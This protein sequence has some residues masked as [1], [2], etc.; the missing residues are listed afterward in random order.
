VETARTRARIVK[1][2]A[3]VIKRRGM[4]ESA[5]AGLMTEAGL[6]HGAFYRH[7]ASKDDLLIEALKE[8]LS[9]IAGQL[10]AALSADTTAG[11]APA[12]ELYLSLWHRDHAEQGCPIAAL[13]SELARRT[14]RERA[15][16]TS[17]IVHIIELL[18]AASPGKNRRHARQAAMAAFSTLVGAITLARIVSDDRLS[19]EILSAAKTAVAPKPLS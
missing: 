14:P 18:A 4:S 16:V 3:T 1:T 5:L 7:F 11:V 13:G 8:T 10:D 9:E 2:A 19:K 15:A 12:I 6:T 17:G